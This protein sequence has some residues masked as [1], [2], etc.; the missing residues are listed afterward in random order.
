VRSSF[1]V[2]S[3]RS[4][5]MVSEGR[6]FCSHGPATNRG[7][8]PLPARRHRMDP[9][10][11]RLCLRPTRHPPAA[12][13]TRT[14][15]TCW[16]RAGDH[17]N[18]AQILVVGAS[19]SPRQNPRGK[20]MIARFSRCIPGAMCRRPCLAGSSQDNEVQVHPPITDGS[21]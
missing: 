10:C 13:S 12:P 16:N 21:G 6:M 8:Q 7:C 9:A 14:Q 2:S 11:S 18:A 1:D 4:G 15:Q 3:H 17:R 20:S 19:R 5:T